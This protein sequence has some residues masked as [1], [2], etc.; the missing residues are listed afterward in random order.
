MG[1]NSPFPRLYDI[2]CHENIKVFPSDQP[3]FT[4][5]P[6]E[7]NTIVFFLCSLIMRNI[8]STRVIQR[9]K[10]V[11]QNH[12]DHRGTN[13]YTGP[14]PASQSWVGK[15]ST[16]L[17]FAQIAINF[18]YF[19]SNFAYFLRHFGPPGGRVAQ[20]GRPW[21]RHCLYKFLRS[22]LIVKAAI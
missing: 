19:S 9:R 7:S 21:L 5:I 15:S 1:F 22:K 20:T 12:F 3:N 14:Q 4:E 16:F 17:I 2:Q 13:S 6:F 8:N 18:S 11:F 10:V